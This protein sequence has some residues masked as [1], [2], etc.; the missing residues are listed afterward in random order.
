LFEIGE[1]AIAS[2]Y[3]RRGGAGA[4]GQND[5]AL[6]HF[7]A[8]D[9]NM[10]MDFGAVDSGLPQPGVPEDHISPKKKSMSKHVKSI[11]RKGYVIIM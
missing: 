4:T 10:S 5:T 7:G 9:F 1:L 8:S 2:N 11:E 6:R 3:G